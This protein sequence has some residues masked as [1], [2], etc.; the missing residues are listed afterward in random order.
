MDKQP[1]PSALCPNQGS[2]LEDALRLF[3]ADLNE[4]DPVN[5]QTAQLANL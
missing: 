2:V 4:D 1:T 3:E 5:R